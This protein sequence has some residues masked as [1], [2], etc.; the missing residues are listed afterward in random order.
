MTD[1]QV[2]PGALLA[3]GPSASRKAPTLLHEFFE[4]QATARPEQIA[5]ITPGRMLTYAQVER[6]ANRLARFLRGQGIGPGA[7]V[8]LLVPRGAGVYISLLGILK[9]GAAYVPLDA[10]YPA[11]RLSYILA[12]C[13]ASALVTTAELADK[14]NF[15][16]KGVLLDKQAGELAAQSPKR[17]SPQETKVTPND[18]CYIIY[19]S[20]STGKPKGVELEHR[21]VCHLVEIE[22]QLFRV[23]PDDR[24]FQG[25]SIAFDASVEEVWLAFTAGA[26][27]VVGTSD[28][29]HAGPALSAMLT[30]A[31]VTVFSTV[32]TLLSM[33][34]EDIPTV[35]LL[36]LGGE[37]CPADLVQR[38]SRPQR[39]M[40]NTYGPTEATVIATAWECVPGKPVTIGAPIPTYQVVLLGE[41]LRP[42]GPGQPGEL[43]IAGPGVARG[44]VGRP[45]LTAERF[46]TLPLPGSPG[47]PVR[48][49]KTGD[50]GRWTAGGEIEY[51]GRIDGQVKLRGFR[52]ELSEIEMV[53]LE[54]PGVQAAAVAVHQDAAGTQ[55]LVGYLVLRDAQELDENAIR[56]MLR[57]RLPHYMV[58]ALL[59][60]LPRLPTMPSGKVDRRSLPPPRPRTP[61][62]AG[63][64]PNRPGPR[65]DL[66]RQIT[67]VW[68]KLFAPQPVSVKDDFFLDLGGHSLLA[69]RMV[70]ELRK[71]PDLDA[72]AVLD[73]YRHPTVEALA[74]QVGKRRLAAA[75]HD[76]GPPPPGTAGPTQFQPVSALA[77]R[78]CGLAQLLALYFILGFAS[79]QFLVPYLTYTWMVAADYPAT[80]TLLCSVASAGVAYPLLLVLSI[81]IKWLVIGRFRPGLYPLW[82]LY[83]FRWWF[84]KAILAVVPRALLVGTP[85]LNLYFRLLGA[86]IG[87]SVYLGTDEAL[88]FDLLT[89]GDAAHIGAETVL[90]GCEVED[91]LLKI[92]PIGI[93]P[94]CFVGTRCVLR[95]GA[96]MMEGSSLEDL[97]LLR[98]EN[99]IRA[100]KRHGGSPAA[101]LPAAGLAPGGS[102][103]LPPVR[104]ARR[105]GFSLL[106]AVGVCIFPALLLGA[107][108]PGLVLLE[109]VAG[110][111]GGYWYLAVTPLVALSFIVLFCL[112]VALCKWL[113]LGRVQPGRYP[114]YGS[115]H[116]RKW[117]VD[118]L[119][120][121]VLHVLLPIHTSLYQVP[122]YRL[123]G[124]RVGRGTELSTATNVTPD[125]FTVGD[126]SFV[127]DSVVLGA[128][129]VDGG[130][131]TLG[132]IRV[133]S[134]TFVGNSAVL[135]PGAAV[136]DGCLIG[137]LST[138][139]SSAEETGRAG[140]TWLGS[141]AFAL[142]HRQPS[143]EFPEEQTFRP[144]RKLRVQRALIE[145]ARVVLPLTVAIVLTSLL[146]S[147]LLH[148]RRSAGMGVAVVLLPLLL[149][150]CGLA[151]MALAIGLK[152]AVMG[153]YRPRERPLW[154]PFVWG[155]ELVSV[156]CE[157]LGDVYLVRNLLGTPYLCGYFRLLGAKIGRRVYMDTAEITEFDL[158]EIGDDAALNQTC[159]LQTHLFEDRVM[160]MSY[161][162]IGRRCSVG[163]GSTVLYDT[164]IADDSSL[165]DLSLLMKGE[166]LPAGT[167]WT[168][169]PAIP[170]V[171]T[172]AAEM[173]STIHRGRAPGLLATMPRR[174]GPISGS[175]PVV[176]PLGS[177]KVPPGRE[178]GKQ[179]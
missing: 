91:G 120:D 52:V 85:L 93:G 46:L 6:T 25:F 51:L 98:S 161:V 135:P 90:T 14:A 99:R 101:P 11:E 42:V 32:P 133:G 60:T 158:I 97:S 15:P 121:L 47:P 65:N 54:F 157:W 19:T 95:P 130:F 109:V 2:R 84:V 146:M 79:V 61:K 142:P 58:P 141:P 62:A 179:P 74:A 18:L 170:T 159:T 105:V 8:G 40:F 168:G 149:A 26:A 112:E 123:L 7:L 21:N 171:R 152:W 125:L 20:G 144:T 67:A 55:Q 164:Y 115:F 140:V 124:A 147:G 30:E 119:M 80:I 75:A 160:K 24:V 28:M 1:V 167:A 162:R 63:A 12:D 178:R 49:Y 107:I 176:A 103:D 76:P 38:W 9:A 118:K 137:V 151:A 177:P 172:S 114:L 71:Q 23:R 129:R 150:L 100:G 96:T 174:P 173:L 104:R 111:L 4:E 148:L 88:A 64:D 16:G 122:W 59:E 36:I 139:P 56:P 166:V 136:A 117:F 66:E 53:L 163:A 127:A 34:D 3:A 69:T 155:T 41:D 37:A 106:A 89:I 116:F 134:R 31:R 10:D 22:R 44:Y 110:R 29:V 82:G 48:M 165:E 35:R 169:I 143:T 94:R 154:S 145:A 175:P 108:F 128:A 73:V 5:V 77:H 87:K 72:V 92:G 113:L 33:L 70:S 102:G 39:R 45:D 153:R 83:Y 50:L 27:L 68:E 13:R 43:F 78:L 126:G 57:A 17:L 132:A 138:T 131:L 81:A 156:V 86:H